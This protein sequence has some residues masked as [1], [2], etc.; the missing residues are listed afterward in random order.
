MRKLPL[1]FAALAGI[2]CSAANASPQAVSRTYSADFYMSG[3]K[4]YLAGKS[5]F[6]SGRCVGAVEVLDALNLDTKTFCPPEAAST[7]QRVKA[8]VAYIEGHPQR[9]EEDFRLLANEAMAKTWPCK[10]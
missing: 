4:D 7:L 6:F 8:I 9:K 1:I 10:K 5:D 3:C 2:L